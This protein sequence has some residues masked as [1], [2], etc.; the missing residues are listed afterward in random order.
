M[1]AAMG[2]LLASVPDYLLLSGRSAW[3]AELC[4]MVRKLPAHRCR[5][6]PIIG[7]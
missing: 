7:A 3:S 2:V 1:L 4:T 5:V 6:D